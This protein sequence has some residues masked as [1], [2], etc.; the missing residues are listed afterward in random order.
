MTETQKPVI[1]VAVDESDHSFHALN[2]ALDNF[3]A[4][5]EDHNFKLIIVHAI[6]LP[7]PYRGLVHI[8]K[9]NPFPFCVCFLVLLIRKLH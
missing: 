2:W 7:A 6:V 5:M 1:L 4:P 3:F 8:G 9:G